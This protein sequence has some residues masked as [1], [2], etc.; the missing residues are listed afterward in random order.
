MKRKRRRSLD[1]SPVINVKQALPVDGLKLR[2]AQALAKARTL[3]P[4]QNEEPQNPSAAARKP[5][6]PEKVAVS[7]H[8]VSVLLVLLPEKTISELR[9]LWLNALRYAEG[10][11]STE[12]FRPIDHIRKECSAASEIA[13]PRGSRPR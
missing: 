9:Q 1:K 4:S 5:S 12:V 6:P 3:N 13:P 2:V 11:T 7:D 10:A 8:Q